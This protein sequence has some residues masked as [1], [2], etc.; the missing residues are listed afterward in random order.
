MFEEGELTREQLHAAMALHAEGL[1][2][3]M[4]EARRNP[5]LAYYESALSRRAAARLERQYGECFLREVLRALSRVPGFPMA[6]LLWNAGHRD[7]PLHCFFRMRSEPVFRL[8]AIAMEPWR[9]R[10]TV[11]YGKPGRRQCRRE[12]IELQR[13]RYGSL[14]VLASPWRGQ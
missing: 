9:V 8:V 10:V 12:E 6:N 7:V 3:E 4:V 1:V 5:V 11:E 14:G 13:D 2:E